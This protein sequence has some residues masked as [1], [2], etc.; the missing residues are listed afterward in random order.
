[1]QLDVGKIILGTVGVLLTVAGNAGQVIALNFWLNA[2]PG[3]NGGPFTVLTLVA[4]SVAAMYGVGLSCWHASTKPKLAFAFTPVSLMYLALTGFCYSLNGIL[5]VYA[6]PDT[7]ELL[8]AL[9]IATG[10]FWTFIVAGLAEIIMRGCAAFRAMDRRAIVVPISFVMCAAG[11]IVGAGSFNFVGMSDEAKKWTIL[12]AVAQI[13]GAV[14]NVLAGQ[15]MTRFTKDDHMNDPVVNPAIMSATS[16]RSNDLCTHDVHTSDH[17]TVKIV[18]VFG[19]SV[20]QAVLL[21]CYFPLEWQPWY[22]GVASAE[23]AR[24]NLADNYRCVFFHCEATNF[25]YY[26]AFAV[27]YAASMG[28]SAILNHYSAPLCSMVTQLAAPITGLLLIIIP[29]WNVSGQSYVLGS[30][31]GAL[32]LVTSGSILYVY[33]AR[34]L[35]SPAAEYLA[36]T[37]DT[38]FDGEGE[39]T[40][41]NNEEAGVVC[42]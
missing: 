36:E 12:F 25:A 34:F 5:L 37:G 14:Y 1:M 7:P 39:Y 42:A 23:A 2:F 40:R 30:T 4:T 10:V 21:F 41:L 15:Y 29:A 24:Q 17:T 27:S 20:V 6:T 32:A 19:S 13:P 28:G 3:G 9:L 22:G 26:V 33:W 16:F 31:L 38:D 35:Q 8:Q 11:V 18:L